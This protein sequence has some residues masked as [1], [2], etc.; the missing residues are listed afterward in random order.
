MR[1]Q[2][3]FATYRANRVEGT[4]PMLH[5]RSS[6]NMAQDKTTFFAELLLRKRNS[7][8]LLSFSMS[9]EKEMGKGEKKAAPRGMCTPG[10][11]VSFELACNRLR[12][13][14]LHR[15]HR[16]QQPEC[17]PRLSR[18][19]PHVCGARMGPAL[20]V[21]APSL[22]ER[23][24]TPLPAVP[25][26]FPLQLLDC[27][28]PCVSSYVFSKRLR[29]RAHSGAAPIRPGTRAGCCRETTR[30]RPRWTR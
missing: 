24:P 29:T 3:G 25:S 26:L 12:A 13:V 30:L 20:V 18:F 15:G 1:Q 27:G 2:P 8:L 28:C 19:C 21:H 11:N 6:D 22:L 23:S 4:R 7:R 5:I 14:H 10:E 16:Q 17:S 9:T